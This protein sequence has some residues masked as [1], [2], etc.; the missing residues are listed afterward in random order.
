MMLGIFWIG[1]R[2]S[3]DET[4]RDTTHVCESRTKVSKPLCSASQKAAK[5]LNA[6]RDCPKPLT[7]RGFALNAF[8]G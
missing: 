8:C 6:I 4:D 1:P 2:L 5:P 3:K 7:T